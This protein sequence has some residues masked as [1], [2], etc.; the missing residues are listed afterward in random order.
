MWLTQFYQGVVAGEGDRGWQYGGKGDL[1][2]TFDG[3]KLGLWKG[4]YITVHQEWLYGED[5]NYQGDGPLFPVYTALGFSRLGG[6]ERA[7][8]I[9]L[10]QAFSE[11][12]SVSVGKF[13]MLDAA[14]KTPLM[15]G[16]G[17]VTFMNTAL[18]ATGALIQERT[19]VHAC[20]TVARRVGSHILTGHSCATANAASDPYKPSSGDRHQGT[21]E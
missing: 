12:V 6:Y 7:T 15:G 1:I 9:I 8:S 18:A 21:A 2:A 13:N 16:G 5:A 3:G 10:T 20:A 11:Q 14:S 19:T 17:L 4:L